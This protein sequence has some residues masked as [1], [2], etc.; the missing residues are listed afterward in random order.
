[1]VRLMLSA[2]RGPAECRLAVA[3]LSAEVMKDAG[4]HGL[5]SSIVDIEEAEHGPVSMVVAIDG[6]GAD[7]FASAW[8]GTLQWICRSPLRPAHKRKNWF[9]AVCILPDREAS[10]VEIRRCDLKWETCRSSGAGGQH[11]NRTESAVRVVHLPTGLSVRCES[12]RSQHRN[13]A[14]ALE[15]LGAALA[16]WK[17]DRGRQAERGKWR[18]HDSLKRGGAVQIFEGMTFRRRER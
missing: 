7:T 9:V 2:G 11:V 13:K 10:A 4:R 8:Q 3:G 17:A 12:E 15:R 1:M 16:A 5:T 18:E 14:I 6:N